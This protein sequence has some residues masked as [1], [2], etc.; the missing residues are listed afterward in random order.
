MDTFTRRDQGVVL[1]HRIPQVQHNRSI[2]ALIRDRSYTHGWRSPS[3]GLDWED[4]N[5][6]EMSAALL[7][8]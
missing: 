8:D 6:T 4:T 1:R 5:H 2:L 7:Q 3:V